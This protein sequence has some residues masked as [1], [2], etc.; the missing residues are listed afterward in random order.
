MRCHACAADQSSLSCVCSLLFSISAAQTTCRPIGRIPHM[1]I[2][3]TWRSGHLP[4]TLPLPLTPPLIISTPNHL[5]A[6][7]PWPP[8]PSPS[9]PA[10]RLRPCAGP[11]SVP[12]SH[13]PNPSHPHPL[14]P[15]LP[16]PH[17]ISTPTPNLAAC[18]S[19]NTAPCVTRCMPRRLTSMPRP[20][21][22]KLLSC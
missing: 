10:P 9:L 6:L 18:T 14:P 19:P 13:S 20:S 2:R 8:A 17:S 21:T 15:R 7:G 1:S 3:P 4:L 12:L 16:L 22:L 11:D 5:P